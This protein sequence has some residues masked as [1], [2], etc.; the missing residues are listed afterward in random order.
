MQH[1]SFK[2]GL[3]V[4]FFLALSLTY[5]AILMLYEGSAWIQWTMGH[6]FLF[7]FTLAGT[8]TDPTL[9]HPAFALNTVTAVLVFLAAGAV[10]SA[11]TGALTLLPGKLLARVRWRYSLRRCRRA[12]LSLN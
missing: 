8:T 6:S 7:S 12:S 11:A 2:T 10:L 3:V 5:S 1:S 9:W 4:M